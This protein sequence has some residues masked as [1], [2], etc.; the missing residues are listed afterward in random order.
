MMVLLDAGWFALWAFGWFRAFAWSLLGHSRGVAGPS[1]RGH[2]LS[3][4][5]GAYFPGAQVDW[6]LAPLAAVLCGR[7]LSC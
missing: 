4:V 3:G 6:L 5:F 1:F 2:V 7:V